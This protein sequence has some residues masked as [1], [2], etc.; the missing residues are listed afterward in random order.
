MNPDIA[1]RKRIE[2]EVRSTLQ[3]MADDKS[4]E[5]IFNSYVERKEVEKKRR[6]LESNP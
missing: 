4:W 6:E 1:D 3:M 2:E 5:E